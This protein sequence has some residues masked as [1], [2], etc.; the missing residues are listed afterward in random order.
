MVAAIIIGL[1]SGLARNP[2]IERDHGRIIW[3]GDLSNG[4]VFL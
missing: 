3:V 2:N 4:Q 1:W